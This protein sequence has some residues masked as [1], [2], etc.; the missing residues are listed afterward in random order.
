[1]LL[2]HRFCFLG[3]GGNGMLKLEHAQYMMTPTPHLVQDLV[4]HS[5]GSNTHPFYQGPTPNQETAVS[6]H[7]GPCGYRRP[8]R[9]PAWVSPLLKRKLQRSYGSPDRMRNCF[10]IFHWWDFDDLKILFL[11]VKSKN[12]EW[13][14]EAEALDAIFWRGNVMTCR[15][16]LHCNVRLPQGIM[17]YDS[18]STPVLELGEGG[19]LKIDMLVPVKAIIVRKARTYNVYIK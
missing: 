7:Q 13:Y 17:I 12:D 18:S 10:S 16:C 1:M 5:R 8:R 14:G 11:L 19:P 2:I 6:N 4:C 3:E 15:N 9:A